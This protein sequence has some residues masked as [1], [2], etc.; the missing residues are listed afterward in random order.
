MTSD[1][2]VFIWSITSSVTYPKCNII[3]LSQDI[4]HAIAHTSTSNSNKNAIRSKTY[5][6]EGY[7]CPSIYGLTNAI[8]NLFWV[9]VFR[10]QYRPKFQIIILNM[11]NFLTNWA[12]IPSASW[13]YSYF[14]AHGSATIKQLVVVFSPRRPGFSSRAVYMGLVEAKVE[15]GRVPFEFIGFPLSIFV[16]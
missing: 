15:Q 10:T 7:L 3:I 1:Y 8:F 12:T 6:H 14:I 16:Q 9:N 4:L 2:S 11:G 5:L 13:T